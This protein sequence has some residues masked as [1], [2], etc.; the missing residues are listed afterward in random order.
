[1]LNRRFLRIKVFQALYGVAHEEQVSLATSKK[2][3]FSNLEKTYELYLFVLSF[4]SELLHFIDLELEMQHAKYFPAE[5][6]IQG[7]QAIKNNQVIQLLHTN[8]N[9]QDSLKAVKNRWQDVVEF[10]RKIY[11]EV[12]TQDFFKEYA[13]KSSHTFTEDKQF[14]LTFF[15]YLFADSENF[16]NYIEEVFYNWE[17]DQVI[18]LSTIQKMI[19]ASKS[20]QKQFITEPH[21]DEEEDLKFMRDLFEL[22]IAHQQAFNELINAKTQNWEQDRIA[23]VD[24]LLMRMALCELL[25]FPYIPVKVSINEYLEL[26]KL[27][28]TPN[29]HGFINGVLD[30][31]QM[32][33]KSDQKIN[34]QGRGLVE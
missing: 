34:K 15:E 11:Q 22:T 6:L 26:A 29:S 8:Q 1:M 30:K 31:I 28:S 25:Y 20:G 21:K 3:L 14:L 7:L 23:M 32:Q 2:Q 33:L 16:N 13:T 4:P 9:F 24:I 12:R 18:V 27:Y 17:D 10:S 5:Q 19:N